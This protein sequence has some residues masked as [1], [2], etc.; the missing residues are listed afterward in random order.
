[1]KNFKRFLFS[2]DKIPFLQLKNKC[3]EKGLIDFDWDTYFSSIF[4]DLNIDITDEE[5]IIVVQ[6]D[7]FAAVGAL[8]VSEEVV[9]N[10]LWSRATTRIASELNQVNFMLLFLSSYPF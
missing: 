5:R 10:Y 9:L 4:G 8:D 7:Y 6:P 2:Y 1:M 3:I